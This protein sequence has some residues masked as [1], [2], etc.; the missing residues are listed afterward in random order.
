M[1]DSLSLK[2]RIQELEEKLA[3]VKSQ[4]SRD[5]LK[6]SASSIAKFSKYPPMSTHLNLTNPKRVKRKSSSH[7]IIQVVKTKN[8]TVSSVVNFSEND[9]MSMASQA[10]LKSRSLKVS[11]EK[12]IVAGYHSAST[13]TKQKLTYKRNEQLCSFYIRYGRCRAGSKCLF[14][15]DASK[16]AVCRKFLIGECMEGNGCPL[17]HVLDQVMIYLEFL[18]CTFPV[19]LN[20]C[21]VFIISGQDAGLLSLSKRGL[22]C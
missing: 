9:R 21:L 22:L 4:G 10:S 12:K 2:R 18:L 19:S 13:E 14:V 16:I 8:S 1:G 6:S 15:H 7:D 5:A 3:N 17:S 20:S 11:K